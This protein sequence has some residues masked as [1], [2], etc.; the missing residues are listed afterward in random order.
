MD[1]LFLFEEK[2]NALFQGK[3]TVVVWFSNYSASRKDV[4]SKEFLQFVDRSNQVSMHWGL[5]WNTEFD[6][7]LF[8]D[9]LYQLYEFCVPISKQTQQ[10]EE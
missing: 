3:G 6:G 5:A 4:G 9:K 2:K 7:K 1:A 10:C 8:G